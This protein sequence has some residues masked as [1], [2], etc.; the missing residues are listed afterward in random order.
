MRT[1]M[2]WACW[3]VRGLNRAPACERALAATI[4]GGLPESGELVSAIE[5]DIG[6]TIAVP[7][8]A[9]APATLAGAGAS[10]PRPPAVAV[11]GAGAS[12]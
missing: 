5:S 1:K 10:R 12:P 4:G 7:V 6:L 3:P 8:L 9:T 2:S 11:A